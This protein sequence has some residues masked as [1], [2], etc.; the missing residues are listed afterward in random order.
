M[1]D[2]VVFFPGFSRFAKTY[3]LNI[4]EVAYN[5]ESLLIR[6][7]YIPVLNEFPLDVSFPT[8]EGCFFFVSVPHFNKRNILITTSFTKF[9]SGFPRSSYP[10]DRRKATDNTG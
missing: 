10:C 8:A 3:F 7:V 4:P 9:K 5:L 2:T 6:H 1:L